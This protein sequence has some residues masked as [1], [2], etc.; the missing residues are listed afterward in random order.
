VATALLVKDSREKLY[1]TS[2]SWVLSQANMVADGKS[3]A[4]ALVSFKTHS[5]T[6]VPDGT[7]VRFFAH[8]VRLDPPTAKTAGGA[9]SLAQMEGI[10][11]DF[12]S[13]AKRSHL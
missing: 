5:G 13:A 2:A 4:N 9:L 3:T 1:P 6:P 7:P 11:K 10:V 12:Q 8:G